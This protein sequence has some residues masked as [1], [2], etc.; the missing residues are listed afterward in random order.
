MT[1]E[2]PPLPEP[3]GFEEVT[4][5]SAFRAQQMRAYAL[6][7]VAAERKP[8]IAALRTL[9]D[10]VIAQNR[11][12][13]SWHPHVFGPMLDGLAQASTLLDAPAIRATSPKETP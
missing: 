9:R 6:Q 5:A 4:G 11:A 2:L 13:T 7:A 10:A 1:D 8:L 12:G 3:F